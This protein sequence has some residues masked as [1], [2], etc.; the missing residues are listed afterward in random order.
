MAF[1]RPSALK[2]DATNDIRYTVDEYRMALVIVTIGIVLSIASFMLALNRTMDRSE[3]SFMTAAAQE[4][5]LIDNRFLL[6]QEKTRSVLALFRI[7]PKISAEALRD[8][9]APMM[10]R[11]GVGMIGWLPKPSYGGHR[12]SVTADTQ[13]PFKL[14]G[15]LEIPEVAKAMQQ[16]EKRGILIISRPFDY[17]RDGEKKRYLAMSLPLVRKGRVEGTVLTVIAIDQIYNFNPAMSLQPLKATLYFFDSPDA[18]A[19]FFVIGRQG[20]ELPS[21]AAAWN[22]VLR[23]ASFSYTQVLGGAAE[24]R[25]LV[26]IPTLYY[27]LRGMGLL[28]W[29]CLISGLLLTA[30]VGI[31]VFQQTRQKIVI[32]QQVDEKTGLLLKITRALAEE[33]SKLRAIVENTADG[34]ITIDDHGIIESFNPACERIFGYEARE[35]IGKDIRLLTPSLY[36]TGARGLEAV[37]NAQHLELDGLRHDGE[38]ISIDMTMSGYMAE[39]RPHFSGIIRDVTARKKAEEERVTYMRELE[40]SNRE[41]DDFAHITSHDLKE[42]LRGLQNFSRFLIEDY[43]DK[44]DAEGQKKLLTIADLTK[45]MEDLLN[46]LLHYSRLGRTALAVRDTDLNAVVQN[47][48]SIYAISLQ[49]KNGKIITPQ[50]L[51]TITCDYVRITEALQNLVGNALKY[52]D[53]PEIRIEIGSLDQHPRA[54]G[55]RAFYVK[56]NGIGIKEEYLETIFKIFKRLHTKNAYGG[57]TGSGLTIAKKI[58]LQHGG[59]MWA[60]SAGEGLGTTFFFT[61]PRPQK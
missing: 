5:A 6:F 40:A 42:P 26:F 33:E 38:T 37:I 16:A 17:T 19:P 24:Q 21:S 59:D 23:R 29:V 34:L 35:V 46:V 49:E 43:M 14:A 32:S 3:E 31:V 1:Q 20:V 50:P 60:E 57:G 7:S 54:N 39:D 61:I 8:F 12:I 9:S 11:L 44:I 48:S 22:D 52:N 55:E 13:A 27:M 58:I 36:E 56:D 4:A 25:K 47:I 2:T 28:P 41:L 51:P 45:R 15:L 18:P 53:K 10:L 30:L